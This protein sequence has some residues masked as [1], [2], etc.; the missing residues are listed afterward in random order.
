[1]HIIDAVL[2]CPVC[3]EIYSEQLEVK[4]MG[5]YVKILTQ[6]VQKVCHKCR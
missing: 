4:S 1:M 3:K 2:E 5:D 6:I